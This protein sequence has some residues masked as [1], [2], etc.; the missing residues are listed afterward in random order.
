MNELK[1]KNIQEF[2]NLITN[3][4]K[5]HCFEELVKSYHN[6]F[7]GCACNKKSR[8]TYAKSVYEKIKD[9]SSNIYV[10]VELKKQLNLNSLIIESDGKLI[11]EI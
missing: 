2:I 6:S 4:D 3:N 8:E 11:I 10:L 1:I 9:E 7:G 5:S